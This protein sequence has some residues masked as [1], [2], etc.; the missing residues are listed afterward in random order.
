MAE[1]QIEFHASILS[2]SSL[3]KSDF[4]ALVPHKL[5]GVLSHVGLLTLENLLALEEREEWAVG[6]V[7]VPAGPW[8]AF[9]LI[10]LKMDSSALRAAWNVAKPMN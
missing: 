5:P 10:L 3:P 8:G 4:R 9:S 6:P 2:V 1:R 7:Q